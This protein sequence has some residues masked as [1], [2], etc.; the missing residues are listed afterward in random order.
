VHIARTI[1]VQDI[2]SYSKRDYN[3]PKRD[4]KVGMLPPKL[5]QMML[6]LAK[7]GPNH[8]VLDPFCGTGVVLMEAALKGAKLIGSDMNQQMIDYTR[9]NLEWLSKEYKLDIHLEKLACADATTNKWNGYF[10]RVVSEIYLGPPLDHLPKEESLRSIV[11][12][13]NTMLKRFLTNLRPQLNPKTRCCIAVPAWKTPDGFIHLDVVEQLGA[14]GYEK[15]R[16]SHARQLLYHRPDQI[17][18]RELLVLVP[19]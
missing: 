14:L 11:Y 18:G 1:S 9:T 19:K 17:V 12:N 2:D 16:F 8:T 15:I 6:N 5:A 13:S 7:V 4:T 10:D 3:R